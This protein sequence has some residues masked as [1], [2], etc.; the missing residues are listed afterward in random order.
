MSMI[1]PLT[2]RR[3]H[4]NDTLEELQKERERLIE[5]MRKYENRELSEECYMVCPAPGVVYS[6]NIDYLKELIDLIGEKVSGKDAF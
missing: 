2:Y 3:I 1:C 6:C 4:E 5:S